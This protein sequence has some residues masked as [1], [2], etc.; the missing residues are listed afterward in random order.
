MEAWPP[1]IEESLASL[2]LPGPD[3]EVDLN[4]YVL[5]V[6]SILGIPVHELSNGKS[7]TESLHVL[8]TLYSD[9][10]VNQHFQKM[11]MQIPPTISPTGDYIQF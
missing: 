4:M 6:C 3:L 1:E 2:E 9:F 5:I 8:F 10:K 7:F 11:D